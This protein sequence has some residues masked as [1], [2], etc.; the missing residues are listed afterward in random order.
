[1]RP[2]VL[3]LTL[4]ATSAAAQARLTEAGVRAFLARQEKA[5]N[6]RD[7]DAYF[8]TF[9]PDAVIADQ[10]RTADGAIVP[11]GQSNLRQARAQTR[12]FF[13]K[14]TVSEVNEVLRVA[15]A[16]DGRSA[17]AVSR[18][19]SRI[20]TAGRVRTLCGES[21]VTLVLARGQIRASHQTDTVIRCPR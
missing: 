9:T 7:V 6:A 19:I 8:A 11:Y 20:T 18:E 1:M 10:A 3:I 15:L 2:L 17:R 21:V 4:V 12:R 14:S 13:A 16:P 5:W